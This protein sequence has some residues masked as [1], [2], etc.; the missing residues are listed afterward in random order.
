MIALPC[1]PKSLD[2]NCSPSKPL[3][4]SAGFTIYS[5]ARAQR[6]ACSFGRRIAIPKCSYRQS[7]NIRRTCEYAIARP[8]EEASPRHRSLTSVKPIRTS[9][10]NAVPAL[11]TTVSR[12]GVKC[13]LRYIRRRGR[14]RHL[15]DQI[16]FSPRRPRAP[17]AAPDHG[18]LENTDVVRCQHPCQSNR[19]IGRKI[20]DDFVT[21]K[22]LTV[23]RRRALWKRPKRHLLRRSWA[24]R[25]ES[26]RLHPARHRW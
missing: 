3:G 11:P 5:V 4:I 9:V 26:S 15:A 22:L 6:I 10:K 7:G 16:V 18:Y 23:S 17:L 24:M 2:L 8:G 14:N 20:V 19:E 25:Q 13:L 21:M 1:N 12:Y